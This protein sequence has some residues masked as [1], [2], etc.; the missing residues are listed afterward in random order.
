MSH[1]ISIGVVYEDELSLRVIESLARYCG[2]GIGAKDGPKRRS[3]I[4]AQSLPYVVKL[5]EEQPW[6]VLIDLDYDVCAPSLLEVN[7]PQRPPFLIIRVA[8]REIESWVLADG[9]NLANFLGVAE[10]HIRTTPDD[11]EDA[12]RALLNIALRSHRK[13]VVTLAADTLS[14]RRD[15]R[16]F[17]SLLADF[18]ETDWDPFKA[19]L[20]SPSLDRCIRN[21]SSVLPILEEEGRTVE[22]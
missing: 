17:S 21:I 2:F 5:T 3:A 9:K 12:K 22:P 11:L 19:V 1:L 20:R 10:K 14:G 8:V 16:Q 4:L 7:L 6:L 15:Y 13:K 18:I